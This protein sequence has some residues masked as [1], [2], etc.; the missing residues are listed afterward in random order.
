MT[1]PPPIATP[2]IAGY[3]PTHRQ[4]ATFVLILLIAG[5][6]RFYHIARPSLWMDELWSIEMSAGRGSVHDHLPTGVIQTAPLNL[7]DISTAPAWPKIWTHLNGYP[8]PP[9]YLLALRWWMDLFGTGPLAI[10]SL[11]A[12]LSIAAI[13][14]LF[15]LCR[16]LG[17]PRIALLA[18]ALMTLA[19]GQLDFAQEARNYPMLILL[20]LGA[21]DLLV[22]IELF[23]VKPARTIGLVLLLSAA[24]LT[25]YL[26]AGAIAALGGY[27]LIRLRA[28]ARLAA[29]GAFA[30]AGLVVLAVWGYWLRGQIVSLPSVHPGYL[31]EPADHHVRFTFLRIIGLPGKFLFG[32]SLAANMPAAVLLVAAF[33]AYVLPLL[34]IF[35]DRLSLLWLLWMFGTIGSAAVTDLVRGSILLDYLR[36]TILASPAVYAVLAA[37]D[38]PRR[39]ILADAVPLLAI[40]LLAVLAGQRLAGGVESKEDWR[41]LTGDLNRAADPD[42]LLV[43]YGDDPWIS[44]GTWYMAFN[45]Y[46]P[47]SRHPWLV[48]NRP[49]DVNLLRQ[50]RTKKSVWLIGKFPGADGPLVLPG[51]HLLGLE[52]TTSAGAFCLMEPN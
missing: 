23:G 28:G 51:W 4:I 11:S 7:T 10:R 50:L 19:I 27:A 32:E 40:V 33:L 22:R 20:T 42:D 8:H 17:P 18:A 45:Y 46:F 15:D 26:A 25:H 44:P 36:Y 41:Q 1:Q 52:E 35:R 24:M 30:A 47:K 37:V 2:S 43:F 14:V 39:S 13:A 48:L 31:S 6:L 12:I 3:P 34:R 38:W 9:L 5:C 29:I 21:A 49:V 16:L